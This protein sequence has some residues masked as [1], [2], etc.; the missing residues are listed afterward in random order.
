[1]IRIA[2]SQAAFAAIV[3]TMPVGSVGYENQVDAS[4]QRLIWL[5]PNVPT[6]CALCAGLARATATSSCSWSRPPAFDDE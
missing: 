2:I 5:A 6:G 4:G 3:K 1:M